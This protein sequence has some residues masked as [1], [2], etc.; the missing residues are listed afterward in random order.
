MIIEVN[1]LLDDTQ[2]WFFDDTEQITKFVEKH[3]ELAIGQN[4]VA[5][6]NPKIAGKWTFIPLNMVLIGFDP[7]P[8]DLPQ[9][10]KKFNG[11]V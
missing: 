9:R 5:L 7:Y 3:Q 4:H 11:L 8:I 2:P 10:P 6:V 1:E